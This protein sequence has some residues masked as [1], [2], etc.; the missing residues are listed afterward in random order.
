LEHEDIN[1]IFK[2]YGGGIGVPIFE[3]D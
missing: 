3:E 2:A 1:G